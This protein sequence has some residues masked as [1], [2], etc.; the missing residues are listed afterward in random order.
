[1]I[2]VSVQ[3]LPRLIELYENVQCSSYFSLSSIHG[4]SASELNVMLRDQTVQHFIDS[5][6]EM[7]LLVAVDA[8]DVTQ[9]HARIQVYG[10]SRHDELVRFL[11]LVMQSCRVQ[12]LYSYV[13]PHEHGEIALLT[14]LGFER[15]AV[16]R[17]HVFIAGGY[18]DLL[19][20]GLLKDS[21]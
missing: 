5:E 12:R 9:G 14:A 15:E 17:E 3:H 21:T 10:N 16:F 7:A 20:Y 1:M 11:P 2:P 13:F 4:Y 18:I 8:L 6:Q 19:V